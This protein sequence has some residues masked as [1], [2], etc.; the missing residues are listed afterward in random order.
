MNFWT[1]FEYGAWVLAALVAAW[2]LFD[3]YKVSRDY[4][5]EFLVHTIEDLGEDAQWQHSSD[6]SDDIERRQS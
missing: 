1:L 2:M 5:E 4:D 3:A 6:E